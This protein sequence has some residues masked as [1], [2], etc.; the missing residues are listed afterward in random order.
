MK[1]YIPKIE[2]RGVRRLSS[3]IYLVDISNSIEPEKEF[4]QKVDTMPDCEVINAVFV[5]NSGIRYIL[6][7]I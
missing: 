4:L 3:L 5:P 7:Y 2:I 6:G 1:R